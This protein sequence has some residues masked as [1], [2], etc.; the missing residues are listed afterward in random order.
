[1]NVPDVN[2]CRVPFQWADF[3]LLGPQGLHGLMV[4]IIEKLSF[5]N[6]MAALFIECFLQQCDCFNGVLC[7]A[8]E[9]AKVLLQVHVQGPS[10]S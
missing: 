7:R 6:Y 10:P 9:L 5:M 4:S 2:Y 1:M 3:H 8:S